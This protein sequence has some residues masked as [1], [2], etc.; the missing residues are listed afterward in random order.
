MPENNPQ[1]DNTQNHPVLPELKVS[2]KIDSF[3]RIGTWS[4]RPAGQL[5]KLSEDLKVE[6]VGIEVNSIPDMWARPLLFEM[7]LYDKAHLLNKRVV[8]EWR[9]VMALIALKEAAHIKHL[10]AE[11]LTIPTDENGLNVAPAF[12]RAVSNL[13]PTK[14]LDTGTSWNNLYILLY[15]DQP[16][17]ITSP[18]TL[19]VTATNYFN[20]IDPNVVPWFNGKILLDPTKKV[21]DDTLG[22]A[23]ASAFPGSFVSDRQKSVLA[24]WLNKLSD[25][26]NARSTFGSND[27]LGLIGDYVTDLGFAIGNTQD[28]SY[29]SSLGMTHGVF[30][31]IDRPIK[32]IAGPPTLSAVMLMQSRE[33]PSRPTR[34]ILVVDKKIADQ[35]G[36]EETAISVWR[37]M[38]L[39]TAVPHSGFPDLP[40]AAKTKLGDTEVTDAEV[41]AP[42]WFFKKQLYVIGKENA[43]PGAVGLN[44]ISGNLKYNEQT[45][46][47]I[48]PLDRV[49]IDYLTVEDLASR[50]SFEQRSEGILVRVKLTLSGPDQQGR[51]FEGSRL[52]D[53][54]K[55]EIKFLE[56]VPVLEVWPNFAAPD[57]KAYYTYYDRTS[58]TETFEANP[59][60]PWVTQKDQDRGHISKTVRITKT[61]NYPEAV[62]C[63]VGGVADDVG[64]LLI[65]PPE[66]RTPKA[67]RYK[68]GVDFGATGTHIYFKAGDSNPQPFEFQERYVSV[69]NPANRNII[70]DNCLP[71]VSEKTPFLS[72][73]KR[74]PNAPAQRLQPLLD[75][76]IYFPSGVLRSNDPSITYNLK[77]SDQ[78][79]DT[80]KVEAF[81]K[82]I[83]LQV[84]AEAVYAEAGS[85]TWHYSFPTAFNRTRRQNFSNAWSAVIRYCTHLTGVTSA[86]DVPK[87]ETESIAAAQ[88]FRDEN[89]HNAPT[90][91]GAVF[92]DIGGSTSDIAIWQNNLLWQTSLR[93]AGREIF[94]DF[95]SDNLDLLRALKSDIDLAPLKTAKE[96]SQTAFYAQ[97]DHLLRREGENLLDNLRHIPSES[98]KLKQIV[99]VGVS[100][101]F[102]YIG[103]I[104][105]HL[106]SD[107]KYQEETPSFFIGGNGSQMFRWLTSGAQFNA[108]STANAVLKKVLFK[109]S[110][111]SSDSLTVEI[112][113][114]PKAEAAFGLICGTSIS[115]TPNTDGQRVLA[116][117]KFT[118]GG[119]E[120]Q[121]DAFLESDSRDSNLAVPK[122]LEKLEEFIIAYNEG[123]KE[124]EL[125]EVAPNAVERQALLADVRK[126]LSN[127]IGNGEPIFI[128]ALKSLL[129][130]LRG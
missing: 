92:I 74:F 81:L 76:I 110:G 57:W 52:Y 116:G 93:L 31:L 97:I 126:I 122:K 50:V 120:K 117:E 32:E 87:D 77:W 70:Y 91:I 103:L 1:F 53:R 123:A 99:A 118:Q 51:D 94:L 83:A 111:L 130:K 2:P 105:K 22:I 102:F 106:I 129:K 20:R 128:L 107:H 15:G 113:N 40:P 58:T 79:D 43:F 26:L 27:L 62:V 16:I 49:L 48:L 109:A 67:A 34:P 66:Q 89:G 56:D 121:W 25:A 35:W 13:I 125:L 30:A 12:L 3:N 55:G 21:I 114:K 61:E 86:T 84:S 33:K 37:G 42:K 64:F 24:G 65:K 60:V 8:A 6:K 85:I 19:L 47:P 54:H 88:Y 100:G 38:T 72:I 11:S 82:Q 28:I 75:S 115:T 69:T 44:L 41:W 45:V 10:K 14:T 17:G 90:N 119:Q 7:A 59:Y 80:H 101:I 4:A 9:G 95:L 71:A 46:T 29:G 73:F 104:L 112:S 78:G 36:M 98:Q 18:T 68:V 124:A 96:T 108:T 23:T 127:N 39:R 63:T 5:A